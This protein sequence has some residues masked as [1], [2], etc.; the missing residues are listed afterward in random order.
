MKDTINILGVPFS[1]LSF[2]DTIQLIQSWMA[3]S[4]PRQVVTANPEFVMFVREN[5]EMQAIVRQADLITP[6][7]IGIV[8]AAR[9]LGNR[10]IER[11]TGADMLPLLF[12]KANQQ[13]WPVYLLGASA[14][15]NRLARQTLSRLYPN[16]PLA[17]RDGFF[18]KA[19]VPGIIA[20]IRS[21][22]PRLLLVG[23]GSGKQEK[24]IAD[25]LQE[26]RVPVSIGV[27]GCI[28]IYAGTVKRAPLL[29]R[30]LHLEWLYRLLKQPSRWRRQLALPR[31]A[32]TVVRE[33]FG[34]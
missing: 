13:G 3:G 22:Q 28:D 10:R 6:D 29:W 16:I 23:L 31:F 2:A 9:L 19:E 8:Y 26:L 4:T 25:H 32:W 14:E 12:E 5:R 27:G 24:F 7:G 18:S 20:D 11:V 33:R 1:T 15:S 17:G 21:R 34:K 30:K